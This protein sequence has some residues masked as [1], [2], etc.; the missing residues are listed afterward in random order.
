VLGMRGL[1]WRNIWRHRGRSIAT[2]G[3]VAFAVFFTLVDFGLIGAMRTGLY[4]NLTDAAGHVQIHVPSYQELRDFRERLLHDAAALEGRLR[5]AAGA[6]IPVGVLEIPALVAGE[7]RA[8]GVQ[9]SGRDQPPH[10][11]ERF[12]RQSLIAGR[13]VRPGELD[14]I[15]LGAALART[16][17]V[18][19]GEVVYVYAPGTEGVGAA[20]YT[21]RGLV[22]L[23]EAA[24]E[25][26]MAFLSLAAAQ[27][28]AA[29]GAVSRMELHLPEVVHIGDDPQ[30]EVARRAVRSALGGGYSV[31]TWREFNPT[32]AQLNDLITPIILVFT[33]LLFIL[34]GLMVVNTVYLSLMERIREFGV[35][36]AL[37]AARRAVMRMVLWESLWLCASGAAAGTIPG[38][39]LVWYLGRGFGFPEVLRE[40]GAAV[41]YP[42]VLYASIQPGEV[43]ITA[44][45]VVVTGIVAAWWPA[46][47]AAALQP[48]EA[49]RFVP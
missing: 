9:I 2:A 15:V 45:F 16:L 18:E 20:A 32:L 46:R 48:V 7:T 42:P 44:A 8:R 33:A 47:V 26:R 11:R 36:L 3:G 24:A 49:M 4:A 21:V 23:P 27:E 13:L 29:P 34:A 38:L 6:G 30:V 31:E 5:A 25:A 43:V 37:G 1:A 40:V 14:G 28:L 10:L 12:E 41:G 19:V 22:R 35:I 17:R 39:A